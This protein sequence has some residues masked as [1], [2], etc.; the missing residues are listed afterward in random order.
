MM[1]IMM[2]IMILTNNNNDNDNCNNI[3]IHDVLLDKKTPSHS[4][5]SITSFLSSFDV[6]QHLNAINKIPSFHQLEL[7]SPTSKQH[8][9]ILFNTRCLQAKLRAYDEIIPLDNPMIYHSSRNDELPIIIDT[10][11]SC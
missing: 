9:T 1:P 5:S 6:L 10:G 3:Y 4:S 7:L 2:I 8:K 11:A